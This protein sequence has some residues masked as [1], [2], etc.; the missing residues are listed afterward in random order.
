MIVRS[1]LDL[2]FGQGPDRQSQ[3]TANIYIFLS[4]VNDIL[5]IQSYSPPLSSLKDVKSILAPISLV[6]VLFG[7]FNDQRDRSRNVGRDGPQRR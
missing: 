2:N 5:I 1:Y 6:N 3:S 7:E 4:I